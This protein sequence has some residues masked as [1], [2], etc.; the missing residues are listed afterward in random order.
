MTKECLSRS[1]SSH[2][3]QVTVSPNICFFGWFFYFVQ[4]LPPPRVF[5]IFLIFF[6]ILEGV[7]SSTRSNLADFFF[8]CHFL[9]IL[10]T[11]KDHFLNSYNAMEM[12]LCHNKTSISLLSC[13]S[14]TLLNIPWFRFSYYNTQASFI[15]HSWN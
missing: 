14:R 3:L 8:V 10:N 12:P 15:F 5:L 2:S 6:K 7:R 9:L 1:M 11:H 13:G 4:Q